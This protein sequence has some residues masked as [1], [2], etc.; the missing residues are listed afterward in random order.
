MNAREKSFS[1]KF[2]WISKLSVE[3]GAPQN[4]AEWKALANRIVIDVRSVVSDLSDNS[5]IR[6]TPDHCLSHGDC[7]VVLPLKE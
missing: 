6:V 7:F 2:E 1:Q 3:D 5:T 4:E